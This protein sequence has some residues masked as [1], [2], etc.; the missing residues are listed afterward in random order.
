MEVME[1]TA[2]IFS[3]HPRGRGMWKNLFAL[4][5]FSDVASSLSHSKFQVDVSRK[6]CSEGCLH[7]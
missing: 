6:Q 5:R 3:I 4:I 7:T 1:A 2:S